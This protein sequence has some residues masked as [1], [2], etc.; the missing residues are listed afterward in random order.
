MVDYPS[1]PERARGPDASWAR[2]ALAVPLLE[3]RDVHGALVLVRPRSDRRPFS[4]DEQSVVAG[5][6]RLGAF[7]VAFAERS[8]QVVALRDELERATASQGPRAAS[9]ALRG[10]GPRRRRSDARPALARGPRRRA[11]VDLVLDVPA[12]L[13][14]VV[15]DRERLVRV[16]AHLIAMAPTTTR[17]GCVT[18]SL[19]RDHDLEIG[20]ALVLRVRTTGEGADAATLAQAF[21]PPQ[22]GAPSVLHACRRTVERHGGRLWTNGSPRGGATVA[23]VLPVVSGGTAPV[24]AA[25]QP[26]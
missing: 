5:L 19:G 9:L 6:A 17:A 7:A 11:A 15:G 18:L 14:P 23:I 10:G 21:E 4:A 24:A 3:S 13:P 8:D 25:A 22:A 12:G 2:A 26:G 20:D 1:W 16:V